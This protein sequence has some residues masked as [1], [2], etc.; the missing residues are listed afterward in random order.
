LLNIQWEDEKKTV[1]IRRRWACDYLS[2]QSVLLLQITGHHIW[3]KTYNTYSRLNDM[4]L[5]EMQML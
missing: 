3:I 2:H 4:Q 1:R 5:S